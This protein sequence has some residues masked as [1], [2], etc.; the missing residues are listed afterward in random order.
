MRV[1]E[2]RDTAHANSPVPF[3]CPAADRAVAAG[4]RRDQAN[5]AYDHGSKSTNSVADRDTVP[6][7]MTK[8]TV[9]VSAV[10]TVLTLVW[11]VGAAA[12]GVPGE[13]SPADNV[14][15][16]GEV[17]ALGQS[18]ASPDGRSSLVFRHDGN[19]VLYRDTTLLWSSGTA[20]TGAHRLVMQHDGDLAMYRPLPYGTDPVWRSRSGGVDGAVLS[21]QEGGG[22]V[23][24]DGGGPI[25]W[26]AAL[27]APDVGLAGARHVVY[28]R[29]DQMVWLVDS[30]GTLFD[31]YPV[32]GR[33]TWPVPGRY[34]VLSKS[35]R[36]WSLS[37]HVSM[38]HMVRFV[39]PAGR[40]ATGFHSIPV[41]WDGTPIQS[42]EE[43]GQF[44]SAG[45]VR[46][47]ADKAEQLYA[48]APIGTPVVVLV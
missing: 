37:G 18:V 45:C 41:T 33:A 43:L 19:L 20:G 7:L 1:V 23:I 10:A 27:P 24:R 47:R 32:S 8:R 3:D 5:N 48:W 16:A 34:A 42:E 6:S 31:S 22:L 9:A 17:L 30:D 4:E 12:L 29:G 35:P 40:A 36:S 26:S 14:L 11:S 15:E 46:Q 38:E 39:K 13:S 44:R 28:G 25:V 21:V 2:D